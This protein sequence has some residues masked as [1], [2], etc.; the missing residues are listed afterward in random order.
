MKRF[1]QMIAVVVFAGLL[2]IGLGGI[3]AVEADESEGI[4]HI[5][6]A[7]FTIEF[8][9]KVAEDPAAI[10]SMVDRISEK[11][12]TKYHLDVESMGL[13]LYGGAKYNMGYRSRD[14]DKKDGIPT[15]GNEEAILY[16]KDNFEKMGLK[17][18]VQGSYYNVVGELIGTKTPEKIYILGAHFD[19]VKGDNPGGD[20]NASGTAGLLEAA[21][22]LS[23]YTFESTIRFIAF[24]AEEDGLKGSKDY[25]DKVAKGENIVGMVNFD[26]ILRPGSD[27]KPERTIDVELDTNGSGFWTKAYAKAAADYVPSL[28]VGDFIFDEDSWSDNDSFQNAGIPAMLVIENSKGDWYEPNPIANSYYHTKEDASDRLAN[29]SNSPSGV[30]YDYGFAA[31]VTRGAVAFLA[32]EAVLSN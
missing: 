24:N 32:Q 26:M 5:E 19:H 27:A 15:L 14:F 7:A 6:E 16:L 13:G 10:H 3:H 28:V 1:I 4:V 22:V 11:Q 25:V 20:D 18:S 29:D 9:A 8:N 21:R 23:Q 17:V 12:Y 31:D 2:T 30:T